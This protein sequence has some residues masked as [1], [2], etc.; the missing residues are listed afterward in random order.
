MDET[1]PHHPPVTRREILSWA[2]F[3]FA[4]SSFTT[5]VITAVYSRF[6]ISHIVPSD[7]AMKDSYWSIAIILATVLGMVLSPFLGVISDAGAL[8]KKILVAVSLICA[9]FT[10]LLWT[11]GPGDVWLGITL[12]VM[13]TLGFMFSENFCASFLPDIA[14]KQT[15]GRISGL[16]WGIGYFGGL[17]S[18]ILV[19][20]VI[21][22][23]DPQ[24]D[25]T[26][27]IQQNQWAMVGTGLFFVLSALPTFLFV[28]NRQKPQPL[29]NGERLTL[30]AAWRI[31]LRA[32]SDSLR[33]AHQHPVL[34][35]FLIAFTVYMAGLDAVIKFVGIYASTELAFDTADITLMF[36]L[37][38]ISAAAGALGFG[39]L[40]HRVGAQR[41]VEASLLLW[42]VAILMIFLLPHLAALTGTDPK[43]LFFGISLLAGSGIGA[44]QS[45]SRT[46]VGLLSGPQE[47]G[48][49]FGYWGFFMK[50][51]SILGM[52]FGFLS[53]ALDSRR[54]ALLLIL[55]FFAV[56]FLMVT[57]L[58]LDRQPQKTT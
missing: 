31:G 47:A 30:Q 7:S 21:V 41:T 13:A 36:L 35:R 46:I 15:M 38:Q 55:G 2:F 32:F 50:V 43:S 49:M 37:I 16:G 20:K 29:P 39:F 6:F 53:D 12:L 40:E 27:F 51:A 56:G 4:N 58:R 17:A 22:T 57:R 44:T 14:T 9:L 45:S 19:L 26:L 5:V 54:M 28:Q 10:G 48:E 34:F 1:L 8:K 3:D 33:K 42:I 23:A 24:T 52:M 18:L 25:A 11:V